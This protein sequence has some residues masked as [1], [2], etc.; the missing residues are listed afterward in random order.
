MNTSIRK[1][2]T[3]K[4]KQKSFDKTFGAKYVQD[5]LNNIIVQKIDFSTTHEICK[6]EEDLDLD[7]LHIHDISKTEGPEDIIPNLDQ[8][9]DL[10]QNQSD[11]VSPR[12]KFITYDSDNYRLIYRLKKSKSKQIVVPCKVSKRTFQMTDQD[13]QFQQLFDQSTLQ[14][15]PPNELDFLIPFNEFYQKINEIVLNQL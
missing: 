7:D 5:L 15:Q 8:I 6:T 11:L 1:L 2:Y 14:F 9:D 12:K 4:K 3:F 10:S 13:L